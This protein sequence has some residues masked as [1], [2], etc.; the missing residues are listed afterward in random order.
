MVELSTTPGGNALLWAMVAL[1]LLAS[2]WHRFLPV[3]PLMIGA[4]RFPAQRTAIMSLGGIG[5]L[6]YRLRDL[7]VDGAAERLAY[8]LMGVANSALGLRF[9]DAVCGNR[10]YSGRR[11]WITQYVSRLPL[12]DPTTMRAGGVVELVRAV[13]AR[14]P[15]D[16]CDHEHRRPERGAPDHV[17]A[18]VS[19]RQAGDQGVS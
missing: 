5:W 14:G 9:Y 1:L 12:P 4:Q 17:H 19:P 13:E 8:L 7:G 6:L 11:R 16:E 10:L 2:G 3:V 18:D 15:G